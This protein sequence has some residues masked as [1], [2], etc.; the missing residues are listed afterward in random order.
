MLKIIK[1][2]GYVMTWDALI[3]LV[4]IIVVI[5]SLISLGYLKTNERNFFISLHYNA[6][7][8]M[9][10]MSKSH[11]IDEIL[12]EYYNGDKITAKEKASGILDKILERINYRFK[13]ND[14]TLFEKILTEND[15][16]ARYKEKASRFFSLPERVFIA[17][18][19]LIYNDSNRNLTYTI[20]SVSYGDSFKIFLGSNW[21]FSHNTGTSKVC[22]PINCSGDNSYVYT[23]SGIVTNDSAD[24]AI[25]RLLKKLDIDSDGDVD[26]DFSEETM[27]FNVYP[28]ETLQQRNLTNVKLIVWI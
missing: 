18:A 20:S 11:I 25:Y 19:S 22:I 14:E 5:S 8:A 12:F 7:N 26:I 1:S 27:F 9:D 21:T 28:V 6:E 23:T 17:R 15:T 13:I 4:L 10:I 24:D 3:A 16:L 2:K